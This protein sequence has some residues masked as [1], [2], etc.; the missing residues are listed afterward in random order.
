MIRTEAVQLTGTNARAYKQKL[1]SGGA[2][3]TI[4]TPHERAVFTI[5]KRDGTCV[6]FNKVNDEVFTQE[7]VNEAIE[8]TISLPYK[9]LGNVIKV[10]NNK[11]CDE[12]LVEDE[13]DDKKTDID[14]ISSTE[15]I[16][17]IAQYTDK[18]DKFSY[19]LM[20]KEL[21]QFAA[22]SSVVN[23]MI[24]NKEEVETIVRY[25]VRSKAADLARNK[26]MDDDLLTAFIETLDSMSTRSAF[27]ELRAFLRDKMSR[28]NKRGR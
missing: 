24:S 1:T 17:F 9:R 27:K 16:E 2:G 3:I 6:P 7:I 23:K 4:I 26:G 20:N 15:Y 11:K 5:N 13:T 22:R 8:A 28:K 18:K 14:V 25:I 10:H 19:L 12:G 21:I